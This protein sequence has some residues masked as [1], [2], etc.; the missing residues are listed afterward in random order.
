[1]DVSARQSRKSP[2]FRTQ[3]CQRPRKFHGQYA[4]SSYFGELLAKQGNRTLADIEQ[5]VLLIVRQASAIFRGEV[6][7]VLEANRIPYQNF[8]VGDKLPLSS[9]IDVRI[10]RF[11]TIVF[12]S[13]DYYVSMDASNRKLIEDYCRKFIS[14]LVIFT[15]TEKRDILPQEVAEFGFKIKRG[16]TDLKNAELNGNSRLLRVSRAGGI[17]RENLAGKWS[18][19]FTETTNNSLY[20]TVE[21]ASRDISLPRVL[22][23]RKNKNFEEMYIS[24]KYTTVLHDLGKIDGVQRV[25]FGSGLQFWLHKLLFLD[26]LTSMSRGKLA[27]SLDRWI[28][29]DIDD[30]FVGK[31]GARMTSQDVQVN[32]FLC[33]LIDVV[34]CDVTASK[35]FFLKADSCRTCM[36][37]ISHCH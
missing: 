10:G 15:Q 33:H 20:E 8:F 17:I 12:E 18:V 7:D 22:G 1:M 2:N 13:V 35:F 26:A 28:L 34:C 24:K 16:V 14:G 3:V 31:S 29:V 5:T 32:D 21:L 30:I 37:V 6:A 4:K 23:H 25:Y 36:T 11:S 9:V 27:K 19:F